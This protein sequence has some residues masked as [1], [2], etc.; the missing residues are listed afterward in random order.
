MIQ[1]FKPVKEL[2][3]CTFENFFTFALYDKREHSFMLEKPRCSLSSTLS[4]FSHREINVWNSLPQHIVDAEK[5]NSFKAK[6]DKHRQG[7]IRVLTEKSSTKYISSCQYQISYKS[8]TTPH[9]MI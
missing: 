5:L 8:V 7:N 1:T 3:D 2:D 4:Q 6:L 9:Y